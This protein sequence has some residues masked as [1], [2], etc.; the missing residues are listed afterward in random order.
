[1][2]KRKLKE[3]LINKEDIH[4]EI[5]HIEGSVNAYVSTSGD[6]Y[7]DYGNNKFYKKRQSTVYGYK[8]CGILYDGKKNLTTKR[9]H[10]LVAHAFIPNPNGY[11]V[12]GHKNNVKSDN[13]VENLYWTTVKENTQKAFDD[14]LEINAKGW[15]DS[16]SIPICQFDS[17]GNLIQE[18]G[19]IGEASKDVGTT[20]TGIL[21]QCNHLCTKKPRKGFYYRYKSEYDEVG[22]VL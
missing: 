6:I 1:M 5:R 21:H 15:H 14:G 19:S 16:Q 22:F 17:D 2:A 13:R 9:V 4:D 10:R 8:Y 12:V 20:K 11:K 3:K 18:F 7:I